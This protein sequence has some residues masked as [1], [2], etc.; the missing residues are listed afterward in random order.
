[1]I[2][3]VNDSARGNRPSYWLLILRSKD[4]SKE[5]N[6]SR[7]ESIAIEYVK[8]YGIEPGMSL[9][10]T[11]QKGLFGYYVVKSIERSDQ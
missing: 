11:L 7:K 4:D 3:K 8:G 1:V 9:E 10:V 2:S 5:I 6:I